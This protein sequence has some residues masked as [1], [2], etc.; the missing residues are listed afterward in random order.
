MS[1]RL[2]RG[3]TSWRLRPGGMPG[4]RIHQ[5]GSSIR[6]L[7]AWG[8][9]WA[10]CLVVLPALLTVTTASA[11]PKGRP[12]PPPQAAPSRGWSNPE[13]LELAKQG[14]EAKKNG[15]VQLCLQKDQQSLELED[16]PYVKLHIASCLSAVGRY[17]DALV[18]ARDS[19]AAALKNED[20]DLKKA[21]LTRV[22][23]LMARVARI[24]LEIP[25]KT[26]DLKI[27]MNGITIRPEQ[28]GKNLT[29]DPGEYKIEAIRESHG[30]RYVFKE[31]VSVAEGEEKTVEILPKKE[32]VENTEVESCLR[33]A[34]SYN[35]RL[36]C[37][38]E[39]STHPNVHVGLEM[40]GYNDST[41]VHVLTPSINAALDSP[42]EGWNVAGSYLLDMVSAASPDLVSTASGPFVEQ[43]HAVNLGGG[44]K[45][46]LHHLGAN[47]HVSSEPD[48]LSR[49]LGA[50]FATELNDK[51]ITPRISYDFSWDT[52]GY[53]NTPF[54]QFSRKLT[55][56]AIDAG[57][58]FVMSP[59]T[60]LVTG[61][62]TSFEIGENAKLYR[63]IPMFPE[64]IAPQMPPG[65]T[66][67]LV[68]QY[69]LPFRP[70]ELVPDTRSRF[71]V[72]ARVNH[73][74]PSGTLRVEERI[75]TDT[76]GIKA[77][78]TDGVYIHDL[79][80]RFRAWP[81]LRLHGQS[82]ASFYQLAYTAKFNQPDV[83]LQIPQYRTS[84]RESSPMFAFTFG[85]GV[86]IALTSEK[87]S[88]QYA[89][90]ASGDVMYNRYLQSLFI[91]SRTAEWGTIGFEA[92][93]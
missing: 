89:I 83:P 42:T 31:K 43:R 60:L 28:T 81:H 70:R 64:D 15:D 1:D 22:Q 8:W 41:S 46:G 58:T 53:R 44:Y 57:V 54:A 37:I 47:G 3:T 75:Y 66:V 11:A 85:G 17:K 69:R 82:G 40:S 12:P 73:R 93:F 51:L 78:T 20:E 32:H 39:P 86:R 72:G 23:E 61:L 84:D 27:T 52:I 26:D 79:N 24:K 9:M 71:A 14:I 29:L 7:D 48:Y 34:K 45:V 21:A 33:K 67:D 6:D 35:E 65:A 30:D 19:L 63:F 90:V 18:A 10:R 16:H 68:N 77:S 55:T 56:H 74:F 92:E 4:A 87:A 80:D 91:T 49:S 5:S 76:W 2:R 62:S 50:S 38:E 13:A 25:E 59:T 36:K 88:V